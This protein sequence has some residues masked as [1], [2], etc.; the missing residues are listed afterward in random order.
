MTVV[1]STTGSRPPVRQVPVRQHESRSDAPVEQIEGNIEPLT[2][3]TR[4]QDHGVSLIGL[5]DRRS[6]EESPR[7]DDHK[8]QQHRPEPNTPAHHGAVPFP[9]STKPPQAKE[10]ASPP[11]ATDLH[12]T[13]V[14]DVGPTGTSGWRINLA[15][16]SV[17]E[18]RQSLWSELDPASARREQH[19]IAR[20]G[21]SEG[22]GICQRGPTP[23]NLLSDAVDHRDPATRPQSCRDGRAG[24]RAIAVVHAE[25]E[26]IVC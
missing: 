7:S 19:H 15:G 13:R 17:V 12:T 21:G 2:S 10:Q 24:G 11:R 3:A 20:L 18:R 5:V 22:K 1:Q 6:D 23:H 16:D 14:P 9:L 4:E 26:H 8:K 25:H